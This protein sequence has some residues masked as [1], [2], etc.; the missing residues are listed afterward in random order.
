MSGIAIARLA[1]ERK[2]WR[3]EHPFV[4]RKLLFGKLKFIKFDRY[5]PETQLE[6]LNAIASLRG[7]N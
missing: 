5:E 3:K 4:S 2:A 7:L 1:E 6:S